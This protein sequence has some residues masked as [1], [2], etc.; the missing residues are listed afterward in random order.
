MTL[1]LRQKSPKQG[2]SVVYY[3]VMDYC[4]LHHGD[5]VT[6]KSFLNTQMLQKKVSSKDLATLPGQVSEN[7]P[8]VPKQKERL[9]RTYITKC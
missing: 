4:V 3:F 9:T 1:L 7:V 6:Q 2:F 5:C 8:F